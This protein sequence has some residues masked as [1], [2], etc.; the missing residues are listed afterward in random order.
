MKTDK[1]REKVK[2]FREIDYKFAD[3]VCEVQGIEN[4]ELFL[5]ALLVSR[6]TGSQHAA[7]N[8]TF[9]AKKSVRVF[10]DD[11][12]PA[13]AT[14]LVL[15]DHD[16]WVKALKAC[17]EVVGLPGEKKPLVLDDNG[18]LYLYR[19]WNYES[20]VA[21][22]IR[23]LARVSHNIVDINRLTKIVKVLF[24]KSGADTDWQKV[25]TIATLYSNI[26]VISGGPGTGKTYTAAR[27]LALHLSVNSELS[28]GL[29]AP[30]GKAAKRLAESIR[31]AKTALPEDLIDRIPEKA[32][33]LHKLLSYLPAT[34]RF[35]FNADNPLP[36]DLL[37]VDE[38][39][40]VSLPLFVSLFD[41]M[42]PGCRLVLLGD[43]DQ[44]ESVETGSVFSDLTDSGNLNV[45]GRDFVDLCKNFDMKLPVK[46]G[47]GN[48]LTNKVIRL[49]HS[50]RFGKD[51]GIGRLATLVNDATDEAGADKVMGFLQSPGRFTDIAWK[52]VKQ[53]ELEGALE[54]AKAPGNILENLGAYWD[55]VSAVGSGKKTPKDA[56]DAFGR[57]R[58]LVAVNRGEFGVEGVNAFIEGILCTRGRDS[59]AGRPIMVL[60]NDYNLHLMNGDVGVMLKDE[61]NILKAY[62]PGEGDEIRGFMPAFLPEHVTAFAMTVH[63]SQGSEFDDVLLILPDTSS[64]VLG[65]E[66]V[67]TGLTRAK[68]RV[69]VWAD[70]NVFR[71]AITRKTA[72]TSGLMRML[73]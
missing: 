52:R 14:D 38:A 73:G 63:K 36:N 17:D 42:K 33:T 68:K 7:L 72:R 56:L 66:A 19:F 59:Y 15:P 28:I 39:S 64:R 34:G 60:K 44:L 8:L 67:Y 47:Q 48:L 20:R 12:T 54:V 9:A 13:L 2:G 10:L 29:A 23:S 49:E 24:S 70:P 62:F 26:I 46:T 32:D 18:L 71:T 57:F 65:K 30:T 61:N 5:A 1:F 55:V 31:A 43:K 35:R 45:F 50:H 40:M 69:E 25:A 16:E 41:A 4:K 6:V 11:D 21:N 37:I 22:R 58:M 51:S 53:S 3:F 27:I